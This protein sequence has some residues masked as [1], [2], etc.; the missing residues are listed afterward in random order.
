MVNRQQ[1]KELKALIALCKKEGVKSVEVAGM[2]IEFNAYSLPERKTRK[3]KIM[4]DSEPIIELPYTA[5]DLLNWS[6][7]GHING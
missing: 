7:I 2:K 6:A 3:N 4:A 5:E 1:I